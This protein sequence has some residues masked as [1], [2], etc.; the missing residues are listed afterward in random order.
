VIGGK[1]CVALGCLLALACLGMFIALAGPGSGR[2]TRRNRAASRGLRNDKP[3]SA[4]GPLAPV[5]R[6]EDQRRAREEN[7]PSVDEA[8]SPSEPGADS[9][10]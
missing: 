9:S 2:P 6:L 4:L 8:P 5:A 10:A 1:G 3:R 7:A